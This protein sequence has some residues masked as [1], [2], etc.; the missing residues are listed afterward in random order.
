[1]HKIKLF[2]TDGIRGVAGKYPLD[3]KTV[4]IIGASAAKALKHDKI[5]ALIAVGRDTRES[6]PMISKNLT[7]SL[8][9]SGAEVWDLGVIPTPGVAYIA[10]H[11]PVS[12]AAVISA[13]HNP[14]QD[15]GIKFFSHKG[16]KL[17]DIVEAKI[18]QFIAAAKPRLTAKKLS[19]IIN[20]P[21]LVN[22]YEAFLKSVLNEGE[23]I[24]GLRLVLDCANGA[25]SG[26]AETVFSELGAEVF[27]VN[28]S[29]DGENINKDSGS[30]HPEKL[31]LEVK[32]RKAYCGLAFDGD[33]DRVMAVD[34]K[35]IVRDGDY[36]LAIAALNM[37]RAGTLKNNLLVTTVMANLGLF[38][39]ME[40]HDIQIK[41]TPVGDRYVYQEMVKSGG[42]IGGEQS[43]HMIFIEHLPTGDGMLSGLKLLGMAAR[44]GKPLSQLCA[45]MEKYPQVLINTKV[46]AK[47]PVEKLK[48]TSRNI[49]EAK[50]KLGSDGRV[51]VRYSGT[52]NLLRVMIEGRDKAEINTLAK[53]ISDTAKDEIEKV[54]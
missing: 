47:V 30:L 45:V 53:Q 19:N 12:A 37:K 36:M 23:S 38:R 21:M 9:A 4:K 2:G 6:G 17:S 42:I 46:S 18:E 8:A 49:E 13:S 24:K 1:M 54:K 26:I 41:Q 44:S 28:A 10:K 52:E 20:K 40:K 34:E 5:K 7:A 15:N 35:G 25:T 32:K 43:G 51:L 31:A 14:Y 29:P 11:Y 48:E 16:T 27:V 22:E 39:A 50:R 33:G 3:A